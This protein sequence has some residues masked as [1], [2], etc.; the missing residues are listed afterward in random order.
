M[1]PIAL[2]FVAEEEADAARAAVLSG[3]VSQGPQVAAFERDFAAL[4]SAPYAC[5]VSNCTTA[6]HLALVALEIGPGDEVI[7]AS[8]SFIATANCIRYC[9]AT[10]VFVDIDPGTYNIDPKRVA[11]AITRRTRAVIAVHQM[12]MPCDL[13]ALATL[14]DRQGIILI[15][16]A[17]CAAGSQIRVDGGWERVG[18][19]HG[20]IAC[21]SFHP[22]KVITTGEG[23]M[24]TTSDP[25]LDHKFRLLRQHGMSVPDI[26]RHGSQQVIFEDYLVVGYNYRM[27]DIQAAV[28]REQL[29]RLPALVS[30]RRAIAARYRELLGN[31]RG[32]RLPIEPE[33]ARSNW[34]SYCVG[35]PD[36]VDQLKIM[37]SLLDQGIATRRGIM[38]SH[39]EAPYAKDKHRHDLRHSEFA[40]DNSILLPIY[41]QINEED[42]ERVACA[43]RRELQ[44]S[45]L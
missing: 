16:D 27:T 41:A 2:P 42:Q 5:A 37:Q 35:L 9:G 20:R 44:A 11:E 18:K 28:G 14:A 3:W 29:E 31:F 32:L 36:R 13:T 7:T 26:V 4:V 10:P 23:G 39:R 43:L 45:A 34:Q 38:C 15:E 17:A 12:G 40:Q 22:R 19:P 30:R 21:F 33:W 8:H 6:L 24:L 25:K 1:I